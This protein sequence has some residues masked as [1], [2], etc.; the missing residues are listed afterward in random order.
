MSS[1]A[2]ARP[3]GIQAIELTSGASLAQ[4]VRASLD[5]GADALAMAGGDG[6][7]NERT[8]GRDPWPVPGGAATR[9]HEPRT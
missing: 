4:F 3:R 1:W 7:I 2:R 6:E 5:A 9:P 8:A